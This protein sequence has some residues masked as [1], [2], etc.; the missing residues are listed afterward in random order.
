MDMKRQRIL[1]FDATSPLH[2][3]R[4]RS[5]AF[6]VL[7]INWSMLTIRGNDEREKEAE[8]I[9]C[10]HNFYDRWSH[11]KSDDVGLEMKLWGAMAARSNWRGGNRSWGKWKCENG[12]VKDAHPIFR[13]T[14]N[15]SRH[16]WNGNEWK[17]AHNLVIQCARGKAVMWLGIGLLEGIVVIFVE[18]GFCW[19]VMRVWGKKRCRLEV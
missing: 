16:E 10:F 14:N 8:K 3:F 15:K 19:S 2:V 5:S 11:Q 6:E 13:H 7:L 9:S 1:N 18:F 17:K 12:E 4:A